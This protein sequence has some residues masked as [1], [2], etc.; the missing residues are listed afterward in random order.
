MPEQFPG[1]AGYT[2]RRQADNAGGDAGAE[3]DRRDSNRHVVGLRRQLRAHQERRSEDHHSHA[4]DVHWS[5]ATKRARL[6]LDRELRQ[7]NGTGALD[8]KTSVETILRPMRHGRCVSK[9]RAG[10]S[11]PS[12]R[13]EAP[14]SRLGPCRGSAFDRLRVL[15]RG[16]R[17]DRP[18]R[19]CL[20]GAVARGSGTRPLPWRTAPNAAIFKGRDV[21]DPRRRRPDIFLQEQ[22]P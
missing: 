21:E 4:D 5:P 16:D 9:V 18:G 20:G 22:R 17:I 2:E 13:N 15:R 19:H 12:P 11:L 8:P 3:H 6:S 14:E 10:P 1:P 7:T